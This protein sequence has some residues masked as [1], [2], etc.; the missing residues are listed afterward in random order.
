MHWI[1]QINPP[2]KQ[3]LPILFKLNYWKDLA[4]NHIYTINLIFKIRPLLTQFKHMMHKINAVLLCRH[5][6][7]HITPAKLKALKQINY[8]PTESKGMTSAL[9]WHNAVLMCSTIE[10]KNL[11]IIW[12]KFFLL[13]KRSE[14]VLIHKKISLRCVLSQKLSR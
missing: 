5:L 1:L 2:Q 10:K 11:A 3:Y 13:L 9:T 12:N 8:T 14:R 6:G 4:S 7:C